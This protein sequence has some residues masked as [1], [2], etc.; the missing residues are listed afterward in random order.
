M[1]T[2]DTFGFI[3]PELVLHGCHLL[4]MFLQGKCLKDGVG[5][6]KLARNNQDWKYYFVNWY[7]MLQT[8]KCF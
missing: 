8:V 7:K 4:P 6:S 3:S 5:L 1:A 2:N